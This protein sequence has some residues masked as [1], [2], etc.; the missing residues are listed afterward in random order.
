MAG[1]LDANLP[2]MTP[3]RGGVPAAAN[4]L[5]RIRSSEINASGRVRKSAFMP[6]K[7]GHDHDGLSVSIETD[8]L[9]SLHRNLFEA[10]GHRACQISVASVRELPA[11]DVISDPTQEDPAHAMIVGL[12]DRTLGHEQLATVTYLA[13]ELAKRA[14]GYTF[15]TQAQ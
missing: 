9:S 14:T 1:R 5:R 7:S 8:E 11:L 3:A 15:P 10:E 2:A 4:T 13:Q 12:P 6:R